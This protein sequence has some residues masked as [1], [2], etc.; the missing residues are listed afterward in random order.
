M[1]LGLY[2]GEKEREK[3]RIVR[4][5]KEFPV[6]VAERLEHNTEGKEDLSSDKKWKRSQEEEGSPNAEL[7]L[8]FHLCKLGEP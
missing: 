1:V 7:P 6:Q 5:V 2:Q 3:E 4:A 8:A